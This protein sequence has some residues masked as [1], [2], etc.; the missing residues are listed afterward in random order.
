M[1]R[2]D[3]HPRAR[4]R[5]LVTPWRVT[6]AVLLIGLILAGAALHRAMD[7]YFS[8]ASALYA[9]WS[10]SVPDGVRVLEHASESGFHGDGFRFT[11]FD[12]ED[13]TKLRETFF[14]VRQMSSDQ[15]TND[16]IGMVVD[17]THELRPENYLLLPQADLVKAE[18]SQDGNRLVAIYDEATNRFYIYE[19]F[20]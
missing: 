9:N 11:V 3:T 15:L 16:Q 8:G 19:S 4:S 12:V 14:D 1:T 20:I 10:I 13:S 5:T 6:L 2:I 17:V 7:E 18:R